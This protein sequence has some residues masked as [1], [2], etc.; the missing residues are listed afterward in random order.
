MERSERAGLLGTTCPS[1]LRLPALMRRDE[2]PEKSSRVRPWAG[3]L[4]QPPTLIASALCTDLKALTDAAFTRG[5]QY[6]FETSLGSDCSQ[7]RALSGN[8]HPGRNDAQFSQSRALVLLEH[9]EQ[10]PLSSS[11]RP[12]GM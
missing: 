9:G 2:R 4:P 1:D 8:R 3:L 11:D 12:T 10:T 5:E 7:Q 6:L